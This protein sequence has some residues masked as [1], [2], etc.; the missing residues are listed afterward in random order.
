MIFYHSKNISTNII[1]KNIEWEKIVAYGRENM[2]MKSWKID[3]G[4]SVYTLKVLRK[5]GV[6]YT[7]GGY[8]SGKK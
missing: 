3:L 5:K 6:W 8:I 2:F 7:W 4:I 1:K